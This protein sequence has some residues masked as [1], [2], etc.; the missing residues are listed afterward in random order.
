MFKSR[1]HAKVTRTLKKICLFSIAMLIVAIINLLSF[2]QK[3]FYFH[4][5]ICHLE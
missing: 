4:C 5:M 1:L 2:V 3:A